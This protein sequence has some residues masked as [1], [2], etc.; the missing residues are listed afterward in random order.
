MTDAK[1]VDARDKRTPA[2]KYTMSQQ[3]WQECAE[4]L[5][6]K[7]RGY[8]TNPVTG[9]ADIPPELDG[10]LDLY[11]TASRLTTRTIQPGGKLP[12]LVSLGTYRFCRFKGDVLMAEH[13]RVKASSLEEA[14][15][16]ATKLYELEPN[17]RFQLRE[18]KAEG[19]DD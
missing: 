10:D 14:L 1:A 8:F 3:W 16:K 13:V 17:E 12:L 9:K 5:A 4:E 6:A 11:R 2:D 19:N 7:V 18:F 15:E